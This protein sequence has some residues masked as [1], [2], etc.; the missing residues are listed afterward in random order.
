MASRSLIEG[1][2]YADV[3]NVRSPPSTKIVRTARFGSERHTIGSS[4][5]DAKVKRTAIMQLSL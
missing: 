1:L 4:L 5:V 2:Y 3:S